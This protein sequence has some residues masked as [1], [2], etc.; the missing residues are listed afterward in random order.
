MIDAV[1]RFLAEP[2]YSI[3]MKQN[4]LLLTNR[5]KFCNRLNSA[6]LV[7]RSHDGNQNCVVPDCIR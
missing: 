2:L 1:K 4:F 6:G 7:I 5:T 3:S